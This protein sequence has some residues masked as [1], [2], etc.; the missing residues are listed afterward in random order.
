MPYEGDPRQ[1]PQQLR[2]PE[3]HITDWWGLHMEGLMAENIALC[4]TSRQDNIF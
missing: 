1:Y 4:P 2:T 3:E